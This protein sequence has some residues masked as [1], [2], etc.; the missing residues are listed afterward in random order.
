MH[1]REDQVA[2]REVTFLMGLLL[3]YRGLLLSVPEDLREP[4][5]SEEGDEEQLSGE[6]LVHEDHHDKHEEVVPA[7]ALVSGALVGH[8]REDD[9]LKVLRPPHLH[10][11]LPLY[12]EM[13]HG[14]TPNHQP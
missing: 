6:E 5:G 11:E 12:A 4:E 1:G 13:A 9:Q 3:D 10:H 14:Q 7:V 8:L 2:R